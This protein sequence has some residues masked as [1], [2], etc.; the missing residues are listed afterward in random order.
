MPSLNDSRR[1]GFI[2]SSKEDVNNIRS[3]FL[4]SSE[5]EA[6]EPAPTPRTLK[7]M[8]ITEMIEN[9]KK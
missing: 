2:A 5:S 3:V 4:D 6:E 9:A 7:R 8:Q 1:D